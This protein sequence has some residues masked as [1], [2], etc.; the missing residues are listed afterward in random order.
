MSPFYKTVLNSSLQEISE[1]K[2]RFTEIITG[3]KDLKVIKESDIQVLKRGEDNKKFHL[4]FKIVKEL[5]NDAYFKFK[6]VL[7]PKELNIIQ[8]LEVSM[9]IIRIKSHQ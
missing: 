8:K 6:Q 9:C 2:A 7:R 5:S 1:Y 4:L 3:L